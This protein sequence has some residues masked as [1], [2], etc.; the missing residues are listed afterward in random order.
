MR[1]KLF[2]RLALIETIQIL[3]TPFTHSIQALRSN[4][5]LDGSSL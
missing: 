2:L 5:V 4:S 3:L 1:I